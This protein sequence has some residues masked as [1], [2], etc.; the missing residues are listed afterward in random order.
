MQLFSFLKKQTKIKQT[1]FKGA[2]ITTAGISTEIM[3]ARKQRNDASK[4]EENDP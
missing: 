4:W 1:N 2:I 3:E